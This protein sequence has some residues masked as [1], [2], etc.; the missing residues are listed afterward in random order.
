MLPPRPML[1]T[2]NR[3][4]RR[5]GRVPVCPHSQ[6]RFGTPWNASLPVLWLAILIAG[7]TPPGPRAL[8]D[9]K[10]LLEEGKYAQAVEKLKLATSL[11]ATNAPAWNYL[12]LAYHRAG[13][14]ANAAVAY[15]KAL[16]LNRDLL[17]ARYNLGCLS[18]EQNKL[19]AAKAE[20]TAY[21]LRRGN[22]VEGWL[23]LGTAQLRAREA[24]PAE[25]SFR[26]ALRISPQNVEALNGLGLVQ[27]QR[28]RPRESVQLF[29]D[30]LKRQPDYRP[31]LLNLAT[32]LDQQLNDRAAAL[33][34]YR[35]YLALQPKPADWEAV[36]AVA[37][38]LEQQLAA[39]QRP[40]V[41]NV[42]A[43]AVTNTNASR[44]AT[45]TVA[46]VTAPAKTEPPPAVAKTPPPLPPPPAN[47]A[48][49][50]V[51]RLPPEPVIKTLPEDLPARPSPAPAPR[52]AEPTPPAP[53]T[54]PPAEDAKPAQPGFFA[55]MNPLNLFRRE[56]KSTSGPT[57]LPSPK[58]TAPAGSPPPEPLGA[59][60]PRASSASG[61]SAA[62]LSVTAPATGPGRV[63]GPFAFSRYT[64]LAPAKPAAGNRR[65]AERA[66]GQG[67]QAQRAD[68]LAEAVADYRQA[69]ELDASYF[70][71]WYNLGLAAYESDSYGQ[72]LAA[73]EHALAL[74]PDSH[75]ARYN[76]ALT[77]KA[78]NY[79]IDAANE[80]EKILAAR[81]K[82]TRA[83]LVLGNLCAEQLGDPARART[84]YLRVLELEPRHPQATAIRYWLVGHPNP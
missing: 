23:K 31:A 75:D 79:P 36:L 53:A 30:A 70:E 78:A 61:A 43:H 63:A 72:A 2:K 32:V 77:L 34:K 11:L 39:P 56:P 62:D 27:L 1:A 6:R 7:C 25:K 67:Q 44:S 37:Q 71:A 57:P 12:G 55:R 4:G 10:R 5:E 69:T 48:A 28:N 59:Q 22:A 41:T 80:L 33:Q 49:L 21:T 13:Q 58:Q 8:L 82:E 83:H 46:R 35:Q 68:R 47:T 54:V 73:W 50:E 19:D 81:P 76:F 51:V 65:E 14:P 84:H 45:A 26:E 40:P 15:Q 17:E 29:A 60:E 3:A 66:F 64:Y 42:A 9:G 38:S 52:R 16:N 20:F 18:L 74:Q 24:G